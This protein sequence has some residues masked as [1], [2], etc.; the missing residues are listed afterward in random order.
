M[1][2]QS[3]GQSWYSGVYL[4]S[5]HWKAVRL[6][7]T[8]RA[9][10]TCE[11]CNQLI[12]LGLNQVH[13]HHLTYVNMWNEQPPDLMVLCAPCHRRIHLLWHTPPKD[14][15]T[16]Q[17]RIVARHFLYY[18]SQVETTTKQRG[19]RNHKFNKLPSRLRDMVAEA[20]KKYMALKITS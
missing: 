2:N 18:A 4:R 20:K 19:R 10:R 16:S 11:G 6:A 9:K 13:V 12:G 3:K 7:A 15:T 14:F 5:D 8:I 1:T 17:L